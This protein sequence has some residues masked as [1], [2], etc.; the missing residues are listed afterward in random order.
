MVQSKEICFVVIYLEKNIFDIPWTWPTILR[1]RRVLL[2]F[3]L[4]QYDVIFFYIWLYTLWKRSVMYFFSMYISLVWL[5]NLYYITDRVYIMVDWN[6][7][8]AKKV[9]SFPILRR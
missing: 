6:D 1:T 4:L 2:L 5:V 8:N 7:A 3:H 9:S